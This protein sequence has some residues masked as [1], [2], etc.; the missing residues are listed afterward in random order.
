[1][2][3]PCFFCHCDERS[4]SQEIGVNEL[5]LCSADRSVGV[6]TEATSAG[7]FRAQLSYT[8]LVATLLAVSHLLVHR[9]QLHV[10]GALHC[11]ALKP[12]LLG[13]GHSLRLVSDRRLDVLLPALVPPHDPVTSVASRMKIVVNVL[14]LRSDE[15]DVHVDTGTS[16]VAKLRPRISHSK[17]VASLLTTSYLVGVATS[18]SRRRPFDGVDFFSV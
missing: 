16:S 17:L 7:E 14:E 4:E 6:Y 1:M 2:L 5:E 3:F 10:L 12:D 18:G 8:N 13:V 11:A 9:S 15:S